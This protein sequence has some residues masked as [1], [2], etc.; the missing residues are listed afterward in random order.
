MI[1]LD[2]NVLIE[3]EL[4]NPKIIE[5]LV[6][7]RKNHTENP[8]IPF[9]CF[10]EFYYGLLKK[11]KN[12]GDGLNLLEKFTKLHSS[13]KS[14]KLIAE[15]KLDLEKS[16]SMIQLFE[17]IIAAITI[18]HKATLVTSDKG[19]EKVDGLDVVLINP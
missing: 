2:T 6:E 5:K 7:L 16:G 1:V 8:A 11:G 10:S 13:E 3:L 19:F 4:G 15:I 9:I 17:I 14:M 18:D 12:V